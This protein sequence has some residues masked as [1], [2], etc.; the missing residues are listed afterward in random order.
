MTL[1]KI[2]NRLQEIEATLATSPKTCIVC[3]EWKSLAIVLAGSDYDGPWPV[4][5]FACPN[6]GRACEKVVRIG[7]RTDGPQ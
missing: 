1:L 4:D 5:T 3:Q 7:I 2:S 6:C